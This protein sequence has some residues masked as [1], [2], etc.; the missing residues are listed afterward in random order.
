[1]LRS[2]HAG[3]LLALLAT[4]VGCADEAE[5]S[6]AG[7]L[8]DGD[9]VDYSDALVNG[10]VAAPAQFPA[11]V[12]LVKQKCTAAKVAPRVLLTAAHCVFDAFGKVP[13]LA[14]SNTIH[15]TR[16]TKADAVGKPLVV[17]DVLIH[18]AWQA[19]CEKTACVSNEIT[20]KL[21]APDIAIIKVE[22]DLDD[23]RVAVVEEKPLVRGDRVIV[24]GYGCE[25]GVM[26]ERPKIDERRLKFSETSIIAATRTVHEGSPIGQPDVANVAGSYA[27]TGGPGL[28]NARAGLCPGDS[29]GPVYRWRGSQ[30]VVVGVNSNYTFKPTD[31]VGLPVTNFHT[32]LD[33]GSKHGVAKWLREKG[34]LAR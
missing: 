11:T 25:A 34:A 24:L 9:G 1:V 5:D 14:K 33:G 8:D 6:P 22:K 26:G 19:G 21:D 31:T 2:R 13:S 16:D 10:E 20:A 4:V 30:L 32:R 23:I 15:Y 17:T 18:P 27:I 28:V 29:G 3:L 12:F 7:A